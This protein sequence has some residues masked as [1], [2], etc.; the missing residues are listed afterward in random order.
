MSLNRIGRVLGF[1]ACFA[2]LVVPVGSA[3]ADIFEWEFI[4]PG[5]PSLGKRESTILLTHAVIGQFLDLQGFDLKKAYLRNAG[6]NLSEFNGADLTEAYLVGADVSSTTFNNAVLLNADLTDAN[7]VGANFNNTV[8]SGFTFAQLAS[9][10]SFK[11]NGLSGV[12]LGNNDLT[13]WQL[14][15]QFLVGADFSGSVMSGV[16]LANSTIWGAKFKGVTANGFT[17]EQ[18]YS[19]ASYIEGNLSSV[20]FD[21]NDLSGW[22]LSNQALWGASFAS[23]ILA[24]TDFS[25]ANIG[26]SRFTNTT[27]G[28]FTEQQLAS[29]A[30]YARGSL[31]QV[32][33]GENDLAGWDL[34]GLNLVRSVFYGSVMQGAD[35]SGSNL[36]RASLKSADLSQANL[37]NAT[38]I[39]ANLSSVDF[40]GANLHGADLRWAGGV[41]REEIALV[42]GDVQNLVS[43]NGVIED[44]LFVASGE[45]QIFRDR[46]RNIFG[47]IPLP[48]HELTVQDSFE[49]EAGGVLRFVL[50]DS[51]FSDWLSTIHFD[52]PV[53]VRLAGSL[54]INLDV[55]ENELL[56]FG[57]R[58]VFKLFDWE[59]ATIDGQF[60]EV[61]LDPRL[62][63][64][65]FR[66]DVSRLYTDGEVEVFRTPEPTAG[67]LLGACGVCLLR[68]KR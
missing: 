58:R 22:D 14:P 17:P 21:A 49:M 57:D 28:G 48:L 27:A 52:G 16:N 15:G 9:T 33:L 13:G 50:R 24:G 37:L 5:N 11:Q 53:G 35:L 20:N 64:A 2:A 47:P 32:W 36:T 7:I 6:I 25:G 68:R 43:P 44:G 12:G 63:E 26:S 41:T 29:T 30:D 34:S 10:A 67:V 54:E 45:V 42:A 8:S 18:L 66:V 59:G 51:L 1:V 65:N 40:T 31:E 46:P 23:A 3:G 4:D 56:F 62:F 61:V 38:L 55:P 39:F 19:T 60:D